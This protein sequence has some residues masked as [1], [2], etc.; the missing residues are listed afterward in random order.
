MSFSYMKVLV[1]V[2]FAAHISNAVLIDI[3]D[4]QMQQIGEILIKSYF[5]GNRIMRNTIVHNRSR[6][7]IDLLDC[8]KISTNL[9][10]FFGLT[11]TLVGSNLL[12][13]YF[14]RVLFAPTSIMNLSSNQT[15]KSSENIKPVPVEHCK[16]DYG[17]TD[18]LCWRT[19]DNGK[20]ATKSTETLSWCYTASMNAK[21]KIHKC[22][23]NHECS[24]CWDCMG[25]CHE[26]KN[27]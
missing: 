8:K 10:Q 6:N 16:F 20:N 17:C 2:V 12:T 9:F 22:F 26:V 23:H 4:E 21:N 3:D 15:Y 25:I 7:L 5:G 24:P 14:E 1:F 13:T 27:N 11:F 19:C 18:N